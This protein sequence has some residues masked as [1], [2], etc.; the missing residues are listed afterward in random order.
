MKTD[1]KILAH[2]IRKLGIQK[3][4]AY[5]KGLSRLFYQ[6][7]EWDNQDN[8]VMQVFAN[9][10]ELD[11]SFINECK[12]HAQNPK[13][14]EVE[15]VNEALKDEKIRVPFLIDS[16]IIGYMT[17]GLTTEE[18]NIVETLINLFN[19]SESFYKLGKKLSNVGE[20]R[21]NSLIEQ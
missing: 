21:F 3:R 5:M 18:E 1:F 14:G 8:R 16:F 7:P 4:K 17:N 11:H 20:L 6:N 10:F 13:K 2:P 19:H 9:T 15:A 12:K